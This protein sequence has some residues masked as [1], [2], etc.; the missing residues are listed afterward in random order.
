MSSSNTL[1]HEKKV[2]VIGGSSG[3]YTTYVSC[4]VHTSCLDLP[5]QK[6][7]GFSVAAAALSNG[8]SVIIASSSESRLDAAVERL[9]KGIAVK[10][11]VAVC[12][13]P[14]GLT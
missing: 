6:G 11:D 12:H 14:L 10:D 1:L 5:W 13:S 7:I 8:A 3:T 2:I 4:S 9:K